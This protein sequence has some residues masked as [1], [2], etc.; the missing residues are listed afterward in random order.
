M[1]KFELTRDG[2][3]KWKKTMYARMNSIKIELGKKAYRYWVSDQ[4]INPAW[5]YYFRSNWNCS[6]NNIDYSVYPSERILTRFIYKQNVIPDKAFSAFES[7]TFGNEIF[8]TNSVSY[9]G[10]LNYGGGK[11]NYKTPTHYWELGIE[12][13]RKS[14]VETAKR[15]SGMKVEGDLI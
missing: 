7:A 13:L 3:G 6:V 12:N 9:A 15:A 14:F 5:T 1:P 10:D 2:I 8:V 4:S 11:I